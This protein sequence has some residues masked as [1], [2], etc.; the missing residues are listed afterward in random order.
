MDLTHPDIARTIATGHP[1]DEAAVTEE[2]A[3]CGQ[4]L[5]AGELRINIPSSLSYFCSKECA[6]GFLYEN[7]DLDWVVDLMLE[8][9]TLVWRVME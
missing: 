9:A 6:L 8:E 2:C 5:S 1:H 4:E 3:E 7:K